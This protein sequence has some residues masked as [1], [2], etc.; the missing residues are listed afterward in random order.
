M[1]LTLDAFKSSVKDS[2]SEVRDI[3]E[4]SSSIFSTSVDDSLVAVDGYGKT[5]TQVL[6]NMRNGILDRLGATKDWLLNTSFLD[7]GSVNSALESAKGIKDNA[8]SL[9]KQLSDEIGTNINSIRGI[10]DSVIGAATT[11]LNDINQA[12][13]DTFS[14]IN[15]VKYG[16]TAGTYGN[17][18][19]DFIDSVNRLLY[20][21]KST[22]DNIVDKF[23]NDSLKGSILQNS[24]YLGLTNVIDG[25]YQSDPGNPILM[26]SLSDGLDEALVTGDIRT[27]SCIVKNLGADYVLVRHPN[28]VNEILANY[29]YPVGTTP[30]EYGE[31]ADL[32]IDTLNYINPQWNDAVSAPYLKNNISVF[33][34]ASSKAKAVLGSRSK[35]AYQIKVIDHYPN[36]DINVLA[37]GMYPSGAFS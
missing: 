15:G 34:D 6:S 21:G 35:Y 31:Q 2:A 4:T 7:L 24:S 29:T 3:A 10:S 22:Y 11:T 1:S 5:Q 8:T 26:R 13:N 14:T 37:R 19:N 25:V 33:R 27:I 9:T 12:V 23:A 17:V 30:N 28:V 18:V 20:D 36:Q 32:L 16:V